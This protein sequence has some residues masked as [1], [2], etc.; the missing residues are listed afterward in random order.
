MRGLIRASM[1]NPWAVTVFALTIAL[2]GGISTVLIPIDIL[3]VFK[4]PA[5]QILTFYSGM[6]P[7]EVEPDLTNQEERWTDMAAGI[8]QQ[9]SRSIL[10][11]SIVRNYFYPEVTE[12]EAL[13]SVLSWSQAVLPHLP[14]GTLP[15]SVI[16]F[17]PTS[18]TPACLV[19]L[20]SPD[21]DEKTL[22][23]IGRFEVRNRIMTIRGA[24]SPVVFG[25]KLRAVQVYLDRQRMQARNLSPVDVMR[26]ME[27]SN[28]FL[29]TGELIVGD[30]DYFL[31]SNAMFKRVPDMGQI[32]LRTEH[33]NRA[34]VGDVAQPT[35]DAMIQT[36]I[37]RVDG[38]KQVY[39]PVMR[40]KGASTLRV[41]D[42]LRDRLREI[43]SMLTRPCH[44]ELIMDQSV[45]VRQSIKSLAT[46][47]VLGSILCSLTILLF[48]GRWR[49]TAIAIMTIPL[50]VLSAVIFLNLSQQTINV[51]TLSG[52]T[53]AI[54]PMVDS[55]IICLE[56][57][58]RHLEQG[59]PPDVSAL[60]GASEVALPEL[61][62][63]LSTLLVLMPLALMPGMS[64]FL[65]LPMTLSVTFAMTTA[66]ILSRTLVPTCAAAWLK[67]K[68][69][70]EGQGAHR[71]R[72]WI[73]RAF[74]KWQR[75][76]DDGIQEYGKLLDRVLV[77]RWPTVIV[78][79]VLLAVVLLF[80]TLPI[81]REFFPQADAGAFEIYVRAPSGTRLRVTNE[82]IAEV[83]AFIKQ[84][85]PPK[86]LKILVSEIGVTPDWSSAYTP[87]AG[88]MDTVV[89]VQ[90]TEERDKG[91]YEYADQLRKAFALE[92][93][94]HDLEF[95]FNAGG[96]IRGA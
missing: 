67:P 81:R 13:A 69:E 64:S 45:Y 80:L 71:R 76:I 27:L 43:E 83:E 32:P 42:Q 15:P 22:Y 79:Y 60:K 1:M 63:S 57:T 61:V 78:A 35:D 74:D 55:A 31:E 14:P 87:N 26:A 68:G 52:L 7:R 29:P 62:S 39:I 23:D 93:R 73:G 84:Q 4:S 2:L 88:K 58:D 38:R 91:S 44:L 50:S 90:L 96:L 59:L 6:S 34:F 77:H 70:T 82:R 21:A 56:N 16:P 19:A 40:Q 20:N 54:G 89:R 5:V 3:P 9:E 72:S 41:I 85:I 11:V 28:L 47:G 48:L 37:V 12:G 95:S 92:K 24:V 53:L 36:T 94:F 86:A 10:G 33:G 17:D 8:R 25:G 75:W 65:F 18:T 51:M 66:Y 46:E 49:M 30:M